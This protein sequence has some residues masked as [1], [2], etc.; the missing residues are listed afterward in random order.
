MKPQSTEIT[1]HPEK[2]KGTIDP[3]VYGLHLEHIWNCVYP[4]IW[5]GRDS[6]IPNSNGIR[7]DVVKLLAALKPSV[8]KYPGGYFSDFYDWRDGVGKNRPVRVC[9]T[10]PGQQESN[11]FGTAEFVTLC[12]LIGAEPFFSVNT[13]SLQPNEAAQWVEY[14]NRTKDTFWA[15]RRRK[16][17]YKDPFNVRYWAIGNEQYWLHS[18]P[19]YAQRYKL[20]SHWMYNTDPEITLVLSGIEPGIKPLNRNPWNTDGKWGREVLRLTDAG[21]GL[22]HGD[23]HPRAENQKIL[24]SI[25]PYFSAN[26]ECTAEQYYDALNDLGRR[27]PKSI[28]ATV[29]LLDKYRG[30]YSRPRLCFDEYGLIH[31]G[32]SMTGNMTQPAPFWAALW[33]GCFFHICHEYPAEIGMTTMP[34]MINMEHALVLVEKGQAIATPSYYA[35]KMFRPHGG[36]QPARVI[37]KNKPEC[38][39]LAGGCLRV[40]ATRPVGQKRLTI[41]FINLHLEQSIPVKINIHAAG[42]KKV[43]GQ[44]LAGPLHARN[45]CKTPARIMPVDVHPKV[46]QGKIVQNLPPH[47]LTVFDVLFT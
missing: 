19:E 9:P 27:L 17:G 5:V 14:C 20:W 33:L 40:L 38:K 45:S 10:Q 26:S 11:Q 32:C 28:E 30:K 4:S 24:Y 16:D 37:L 36:A 42:I 15:E 1:V 25:H 47:S 44:I 39:G 35:F 6:D 34:G 2:V 3:N 43:H 22:F 21:Q 23:W 31:G 8:C 29:K 7:K 41:S 12:R 13:T 46:I 18:A